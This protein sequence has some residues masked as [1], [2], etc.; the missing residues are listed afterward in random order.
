ML[1]IGSEPMGEAGGAMS[2]PIKVKMAKN[3]R[4]KCGIELRRCRHCVGGGSVYC[5]HGRQRYRC[6]RCLLF[7]AEVRKLHPKPVGK[8]LEA[9]VSTRNI[10]KTMKATT[11]DGGEGKI[12]ES[13]PLSRAFTMATMSPKEAPSAIPTNCTQ[14]QEGGRGKG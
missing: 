7:A 8:A 11:A 4:C 12:E 6:N 10:R 2:T 14:A 5:V 3:A 9:M 1:L 13:I